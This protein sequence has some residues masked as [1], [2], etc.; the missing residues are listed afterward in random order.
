[1][2]QAIALVQED[3]GQPVWAGGGR[4]QVA[5]IGLPGNVAGQA[6][7]VLADGMQPASRPLPDAYHPWASCAMPSALQ[8]ASFA[9]SLMFED[10]K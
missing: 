5:A 3:G 2:L 7:A 1:M 6:G 4:V 9:H 10:F 8:S